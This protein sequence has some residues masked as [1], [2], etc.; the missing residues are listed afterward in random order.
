MATSPTDEL[1]MQKTDINTEQQAIIKRR[2]NARRTA[3]IIGLIAVSVYGGFLASV[4]L[5][6]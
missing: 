5:A 6:K 1:M 4:M 2:T 3:L